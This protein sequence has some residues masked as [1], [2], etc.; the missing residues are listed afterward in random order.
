VAF[1]VMHTDALEVSAF[2]HGDYMLKMN[3]WDRKLK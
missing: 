1:Y 3:L 2:E